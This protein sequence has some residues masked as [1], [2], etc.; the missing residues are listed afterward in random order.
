MFSREGRGVTRGWGGGASAEALPH[1]MLMGDALGDACRGALGFAGELRVSS[2]ACS[3][4]LTRQT[5]CS[6]GAD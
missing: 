6:L 3:A 5:K 1:P 2:V 4:W